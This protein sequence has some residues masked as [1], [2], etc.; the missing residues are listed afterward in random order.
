MITSI[1]SQ[2][3]RQMQSRAVSCRPVVPGQGQGKAIGRTSSGRSAGLAVRYPIWPNEGRGGPLR[4]SE[5]GG[6]NLIHQGDVRH[7][8]EFRSRISQQSNTRRHTLVA[9]SVPV[10]PIK[11]SMASQTSTSRS[12]VLIA[13][14]HRPPPPLRTARVGSSINDSA[15]TC[16]SA[17]R[18]ARP[19]RA[20]STRGRGTYLDSMDTAE[21]CLPSM[22]D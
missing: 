19:C 12:A 4:V 10:E 18:R 13:D 15:G 14:P 17:N 7:V 1:R 11:R 22:A 3:A 2:A 9:V 8:L 6:R 21:P 16:G 5:G 20:G